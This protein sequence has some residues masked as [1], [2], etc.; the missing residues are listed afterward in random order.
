MTLIIGAANHDYVI[1]IADRRMTGPGGQVFDDESNKSIILR[2]ANARFAIGFSGLAGTIGFNTRRW[3]LSALDAASLPDRT[4]Q[5]L[6]ERLTERATKQFQNLPVSNEHKRLSIMG[7]GYLDHH[8]PPLVG[9]VLI[10]NWHDLDTGERSDIAWDEFRCFF[11]QDARPQDERVALTYQIG[12]LPPFSRGDADKIKSLLEDRKPASA[13]V[14]KLV[15][16]LRGCAG[17]PCGGSVI[18][19][20]LMSIMIPGDRSQS[21]ACNYHSSCVKDETFMPDQVLVVS[22]KLHLSVVDI[23]VRPVDRGTNPISI[24]HLK[25]SQPCWCRSGKKF[26]HC[27]GKKSIKRV[28]FSIVATPDP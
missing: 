1:H 11:R 17:S 3:L 23:S 21:I 28:P 27:H 15:E 26:K 24:P 22:E 12:T 16:F 8:D 20:Q 9:L 19:K 18:G 5:K 13:V 2:C 6:F 7:L 25:Q 10:T 14:G 4:A